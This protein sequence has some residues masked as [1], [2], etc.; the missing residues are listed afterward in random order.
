MSDGAYYPARHDP[1]NPTNQQSYYPDNATYQQPYYPAYHY[2]MPP[3]GYLTN[4]HAHTSPSSTTPAPTFPQYYT[5][6]KPLQYASS[7][8]VLPAGYPEQAYTYGWPA[9]AAYSQYMPSPNTIDV[10]EAYAR[11]R[12]PDDEYAA[13]QHKRSRPEASAVYPTSRPLSSNDGGR[14]SGL[15]PGTQHNPFEIDASPEKAVGNRAGELKKNLGHSNLPN[16]L[17][18]A[19]LYV[20][21]PDPSAKKSKLYAVPGGR[22]PG[23]YT[24]YQLVMQQTDK[25]PDS[26][27]KKFGSED[28]AW[29]FMNANRQY[30]E[31][32]LQRPKESDRSSYT[33][34][35]PPYTPHAYALPTPPSERCA[36]PANDGTSSPTERPLSANP[37]DTH[38]VHY[39]PELEPTLSTEQQHVV[40]L[41][42]RG[43][44]VFYTG[45]AGCGKSTIL[46]A[47]VRKLKEQGKHVQI[48]AP[49][50][51]AALNVN[52]QTIWSFAGWTPNSIKKS[53]DKLK[54]AACGEESWERFNMVD[55]LIIDEI[56][57]IENHMLERLSQVMSSARGPDRGPFGG[58]QVVCTGD[59]FQLSPV[60]PFAHCLG[61]GWD[62]KRAFRNSEI[63]YTCD[64]R[65]CRYSHFLDTD[66]WAFCSKA[67]QECD[68]E[69]INL[70]EIHRQSDKKFISI[71]QKIR[72]DGTIVENHKNILLNHKSEAEGGVKLFSKVAA[73]EK[74]NRENID[75]LLSEPIDY[76][77][78]DTFD[79]RNRED[80]SLSKYQKESDKVPGT[81]QQL[82]DHRYDA[83]IRLKVGMRVLLKAN[84]EPTSG[85]VNGAQGTLI[86]LEPFDEHKLP[87]KS[88][89]KNDISGS[90]KGS[91]AKYAERQIKVYADRNQRKP[92]PIV[93]FDN[94][95]TRTIY[96]DCTCNEVGDDEPVSV[97]SRTQIPLVA[98]WALSIHRAQGMT[99]DRVIVDLSEVFESSQSVEL[100]RW[101][102]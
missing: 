39:V 22:I 1:D 38:A 77:S 91:H 89:S 62:L 34:P 40:D 42:M 101:E 73:V 67:W 21:K 26:R 78:L 65:Q 6:S 36:Q 25:Y 58:V 83:N 4:E 75:K 57:M 53:L 93:Q 52:G 12:K 63:K 33:S 9:P 7:V 87:R 90:I 54:S 19:G 30:V 5:P 84:V 69:H 100:A 59:F 102:V 46:K 85:L 44:N 17:R 56:S 24:D 41:V 14:V 60:K 16:D 71:L 61:C 80:I 15:P 94:G 72:I 96:A 99:L 88:E 97:L 10:S 50:N 2:V 74:E 31:T 51:L 55:V 68:F 64:N 76:K 98:G 81:L 66:K 29:E 32:A 18:E 8:D 37:P 27:H 43:R 79:W 11:K 95:L 35:P 48:I 13:A 45:S 20:Q 92:W 70:T 49:T 3:S 47:V 28:E 23:I 82:N 86:D